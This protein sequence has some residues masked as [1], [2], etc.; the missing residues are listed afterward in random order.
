MP[1]EPQR[2][3]IHDDLQ[4]KVVHS[5]TAHAT[6]VPETRS[7]RVRRESLNQIARYRGKHMN[8]IV[9]ADARSSFCQS[10][11]GRLSSSVL[12]RFNLSNAIPNVRPANANITI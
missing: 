4:E 11:T 2:K 5:F 6:V 10:V 12:T 7:G 1:T 8:T 3:L 9:A